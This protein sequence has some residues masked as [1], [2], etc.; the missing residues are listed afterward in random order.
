[1]KPMTPKDHKAE[2]RFAGVVVT[3]NIRNVVTNYNAM[4]SNNLFKIL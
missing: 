1:M 3:K 4:Y 2:M